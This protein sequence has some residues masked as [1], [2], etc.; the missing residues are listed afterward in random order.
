MRGGGVRKTPPKTKPA[1]KKIL[2]SKKPPPPLAGNPRQ[3]GNHQ[4]AEQ[5]FQYADFSSSSS[6]YCFHNT[7]R[8]CVPWPRVSSPMGIKTNRAFF[9]FLISFAAKPNSGGLMK[10]SADLMHTPEPPI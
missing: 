1:A 4:L 2:Q 9:T 5:S 3:P 8:V 10:S 7:A 6:R